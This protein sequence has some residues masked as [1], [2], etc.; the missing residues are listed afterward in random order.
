[1]ARASVFSTGT[2]L[3]RSADRRLLVLTRASAGASAGGVPDAGVE[4]IQSTRSWFESGI[5][6]PQSSIKTSEAPQQLFS[7]GTVAMM[8][9]GTSQMSQLH[10]HMTDEWGITY[11]L[12]DLHP[13]SDL[14]GNTMVAAKDTKH[15]E[16][17]A[18]FLQFLTEPEQRSKFC[19]TVGFLPP[20]GRPRH[21]RL[22]GRP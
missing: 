2:S 5:V 6:P 11:L 4:T 12:R 15:P 19:A 8:L 14:G 22:Q 7:T 9:K 16:L 21:H 13:A 18:D 17:A 3:P 1:M 20:P 10:E